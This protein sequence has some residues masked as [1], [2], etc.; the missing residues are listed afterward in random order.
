MFWHG[1]KRRFEGW[2][3]N[4]QAPFVRT[5]VGIDTLDHELDIVVEIDGKWLFKDRDE[6]ETSV[7]YGRFT[8]TEADSILAVGRRLGRMLDAGQ[9]WWGKAWQSWT[10]ESDWT[11]PRPLPEGWESA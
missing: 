7:T 1:H 5:L 11:I 8:R 9:Q 4:L 10:P 2:Y 3:V 6:L